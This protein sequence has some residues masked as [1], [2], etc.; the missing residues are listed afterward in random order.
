MH[1]RNR[2]DEEAVNSGVTDKCRR[3]RFKGCCGDDIMESIHERDRA[4]KKECFKKVTG[5][6]HPT[7]HDPFK[8]DKVEGF[9]KNTTVSN[10]FI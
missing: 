1:V 8:C 10:L 6:E 5:K 2:R 3:R 7:P 9:K 4:I